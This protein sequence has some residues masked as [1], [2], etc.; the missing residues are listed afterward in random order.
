MKTILSDTYIGHTSNITTYAHNARKFL[1]D[2][3][4]RITFNHDEE[5]KL[6]STQDPMLRTLMSELYQ[7]ALVEKKLSDI[8][9]IIL[10]KIDKIPS[11][12]LISWLDIDTMILRNTDKGSADILNSITEYRDKILLDVTPF[13]SEKRRAI[14]DTTGF[15]S[16]VIRGM[17]CRSYQFFDRNWLTPNLIYYLAKFYGIILSTKIGRVYN[18]N[19]QEQYVIATIL[20]CF[21]VNRCCIS[22]RVINPIMSKMDFLR[23]SVDTKPIFDY[24]EEKYTDE[25]FDLNAVVDSIVEL[26]PA[27]ISN[28]NLSTFLQMNLSLTSNQMISL[29]ALE[30]PPYWAHIL[31]SAMSGDKSS[32]Y[33]NIKSLRLNKE[34]MEFHNE[35]LKT[36]SFIRNLPTGRN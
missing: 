17:L 9:L 15:Y 14:T 36:S 26:G 2:N 35:I 12:F 13:Y 11:W 4:N 16:R 21:F 18:L 34:A 19:Y 1:L 27:R 3:V 22:N 33:H 24:I 10:D 32:I 28:F 25:N 23:K 7:Q 20:V 8:K 31:I 5:E 30:Y 6:L 29:V